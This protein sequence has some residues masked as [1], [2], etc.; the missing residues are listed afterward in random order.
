MSIYHDTLE[1]GFLYYVGPKERTTR[2]DGFD[3]LRQQFLFMEPRKGWRGVYDKIVAAL[4]G[5]ALNMVSVSYWASCYV[6]EGQ[7]VDFRM[8]DGRLNISAGLVERKENLS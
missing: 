2:G 1:S 3:Y 6:R 5:R 8:G 7:D 4:T